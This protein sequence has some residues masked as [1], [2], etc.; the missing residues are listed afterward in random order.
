MELECLAVVWAIEYFYQYLGNNH[1]YLVTDHA[2]FK[3]LWTN[4]LLRIYEGIDV[5]NNE[6]TLQSDFEED[7][8]DFLNQ[9]IEEPMKLLTINTYEAQEIEPITN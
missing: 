3:W 6:E 9:I 5:S 7:P 1:F 2:A 4:A 8:I